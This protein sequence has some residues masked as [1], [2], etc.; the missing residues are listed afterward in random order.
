MQF[1]STLVASVQNPIS[2]HMNIHMPMSWDMVYCNL[3]AI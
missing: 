1:K 2:Y 3:P